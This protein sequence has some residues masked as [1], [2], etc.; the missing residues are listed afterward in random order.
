MPER[1][2]APPASSAIGVSNVTDTLL[3]VKIA[4]LYKIETTQSI[5]RTAARYWP[6]GRQ[7]R[8]H[9][10]VHR[11]ARHPRRTGVTSNS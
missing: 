8:R 1:P 10:I 7:S 5:G 11:Q 6:Q 2:S 9:A 3:P 4:Y